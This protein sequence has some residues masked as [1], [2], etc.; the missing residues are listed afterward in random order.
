[1][2]YFSYLRKFVV[3]QTEKKS[4]KTGFHPKTRQAR[5]YVSCTA[6]ITLLAKRTPKLTLSL[7][8]KP[9]CVPSVVVND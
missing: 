6:V 1:M 7:Q 4:F 9:E 2:F 3:F 8:D 5:S